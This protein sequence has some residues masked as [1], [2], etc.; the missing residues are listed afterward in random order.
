MA[1]AMSC[2]CGK[3]YDLKDDYAGRKVKCGCGTVLTVPLVERL[4]Q[5]D[6]IF[7]R[8]LFLLRQKHLALTA[9]YYV[10]DEQGSTIMFIVQV[11]HHLRNIV[12]LVAGIGAALLVFVGAIAL[13]ISM[14]TPDSPNSGGALL[15]V[16]SPFI[17][18]PVAV[19]VYIALGRK[20]EIKFYRDESA[21]D[22]VLE[23]M[24]EKKFELITARFTLLDEQ[25]EPLARFHKNYLYNLIRRRWVVTT[26]EGE[27]LCYATEDSLI[28]S[29]LRRFLGPM[30]GLLRTNFVIYEGDGSEQRLLGEFQRKFTLLDRYA[31]DLKA[32]RTRLLDRRVAIALGVLLDTGEKR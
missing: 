1:I 17:A 22:Q 5:V 19:I 26:P 20:R 27:P 4:A 28:L 25:G 13:T 18:V 31:L 6:P 23:V 21:S 2:E 32:D 8:D 24:P 16:I 12:A 29:L 30:F 7:D 9:K 14:S 3:R 15:L 10:W 11:A